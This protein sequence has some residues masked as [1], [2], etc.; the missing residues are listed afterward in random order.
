MRFPFPTNILLNSGASPAGTG[1]AR[2]WWPHQ[3]LL[4][5]LSLAVSLLFLREPGFGDDLT[6]WSLAFDLHDVG[7]A[8][9][10]ERS[11]HDLRW[12]V[13]GVSWL[14][15]ALFGPGLASFYCVPALYLAAGSAVA[16]TFGRKVLG[17]L[18]AGWACAV[19]LL[20]LPM[21]D[22]VVSRPMP[23]LSE[24]V[25]GTCALLGWWMMMHASQPRRAWLA[26]LLCGVSIG[27]AFSNRITG[28]FIVPV[29]VVATLLFHPRRWFWL[30]VPGLVAALFFSVEGAIY[31]RVCGDWLHSIHANLNGRGATDTQIMPAWQLPLRYLGGFFK[32]NRL[33]PAFAVLAVLGLWSGCT[34]WG[35]P[36]RL[37][38][39]WF[40]VLYLEYSCAVQSIDPIRPLIGSTIRYLAGVSMP[41]SMLVGLGALE[42]ARLFTFLSW[43]PARRL[44]EWWKAHVFLGSVG[45]VAALALFTSRPA[46]DL[47]FTRDLHRRMATL[48]DGTKIFTHHS[49]RNVAFLT[50][51]AEARRFTW[52]MPKVI[53][54]RSDALEA[55]VAGCDEFWYLRKQLW[56]VNRKRMEREGSGAQT[57]LGSY[58]DAPERDWILADVLAK[59]SDPDLVFY[60]RRAPGSPPPRSFA[61][62]SPEFRDLLPPLPVVWESERDERRLL[63]KW[64]VPAVLRG[65]RLSLE[66]QAASETVEPLIVKLQFMAGRRRGP[67]FLLK[68]IVHQGGGKDF[69]AVPIPADADSCTVELRFAGK[70]K[71]L[72]VSGFRAYFDESR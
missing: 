34:R 44:C 25:F 56:M 43:P 5:L 64:T 27:L 7:A 19:A 6:Y 8:E 12:P 45:A 38:V 57:M 24:S 40:V 16:F 52:V 58:F 26:G 36:G 18:A 62:D 53:M 28:I 55:Q 37:V 1:T 59:G 49:M 71:R 32:A 54:E 67:D 70:T 17:S 69:F 22:P 42:A 68:P 41:M 13:W 4:A 51:P 10:S 29:L 9:W 15:Q 46:V 39:T 72:E 65:T 61:A 50:A 3:L 21:L 63:T 48:H 23:D 2:R 20:F 11:F 33:A 14:W 47:G 35:R 31:Y 66:F 60:R 30:L